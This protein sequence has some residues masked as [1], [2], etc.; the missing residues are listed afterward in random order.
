MTL[1]Y[2]PSDTYASSDG[3]RLGLSIFYCIGLSLYCG[4]FALFTLQL[5]STIA[6][7]TPANPS[8]YSKFQDFNRHNAA[9]F[10]G[11]LKVIL[12]I[13]GVGTYIFA[14]IG[15]FIQ[16]DFACDLAWRAVTPLYVNAKFTIY[17]FLLQRGEMVSLSKIKTPLEKLVQ[18]TVLLHM[19]Y[20]YFPYYVQH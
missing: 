8:Q 6:R 15:Q 1:P 12:A 3:I 17:L 4:Y 9:H 10:V 2:D 20:H 19:Q 14:L 11:L 5:Y 16:T 7:T 18:F 13:F